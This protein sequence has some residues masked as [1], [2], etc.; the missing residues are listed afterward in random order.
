MFCQFG[1]PIND[2]GPGGTAVCRNVVVN[3]GRH[4]ASS[5]D[6]IGKAINLVERVSFLETGLYIRMI[7]QLW[8]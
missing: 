8:I 1:V 3:N 2:F 6:E 5:L 4:S 7:Y